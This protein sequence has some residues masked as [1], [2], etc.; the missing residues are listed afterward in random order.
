[1]MR[2]MMVISKMMM[3]TIMMVMMEL[4]MTLNVSSVSD[5]LTWP[6]TEDEDTITMATS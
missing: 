4:M 5:I 2:I 6:N 1:M 3:M